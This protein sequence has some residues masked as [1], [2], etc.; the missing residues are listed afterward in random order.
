MATLRLRELPSIR[1]LPVTRELLF[2][3]LS[4]DGRIVE[5]RDVSHWRIGRRDVWAIRH[6]DLVD[7]VLHDGS[8]RYHKSIEYELL[9]AVVGLSLFTDEDDSWRRHRML[10][11]PV[12]AK[13][14]VQGM[15]ELMI[16]PI[17]SPGFVSSYRR[18]TRQFDA[19]RYD[20]AA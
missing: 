20:V 10:L 13:R 1:G 7:H 9:R 18:R 11:N 14:H 5:G 8:D 19:R 2:D 6:P 17:N 15:C 12:M 4:I 16:D 3:G